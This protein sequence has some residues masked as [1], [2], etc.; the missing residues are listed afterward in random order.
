MQDARCSTLEVRCSEFG[1]LG[2]LLNSP[3][4]QPILAFSKHLL[5][6]MTFLMAWH[7][8]ALTPLRADVGDA[9]LRQLLRHIAS[10]LREADDPDARW[11]DQ[12]W[13]LLW[14]ALFLSLLTFRRGWTMQW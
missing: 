5:L 12:A 1:A 13:W 4:R 9:D 14:P 7:A 3:C 6:P 2:L 8:T 11:R 10:N